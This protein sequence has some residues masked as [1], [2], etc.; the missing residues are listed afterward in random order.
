MI[1]MN[2]KKKRIINDTEWVFIPTQLFYFRRCMLMFKKRDRMD[3]DDI[4]NDY[5]DYESNIFSNKLII[6]LSI[7]IAAMILVPIWVLF[8]AYVL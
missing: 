7:Y 6:A 3:N 5:V 2:I 4:H 1:L 8:M